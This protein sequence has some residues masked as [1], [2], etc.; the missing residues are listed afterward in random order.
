[1]TIPNHDTYGSRF[2][3]CY[4]F[5]FLSRNKSLMLSFNYEMIIWYILEVIELIQRIEGIS[6]EAD[7][8]GWT[9]LHLVAHY[10][11]IKSTMLLLEY[12]RDVAYM[13]DKDGR[14]AL[15]IAAH[16]G[17]HMVME[18]I[19]SS[20]P[21]CCELVDKR[22]WNVLHFA[23]DDPILDDFEAYQHIKLIIGAIL[24]NRSL[25]NLLNQKDTDG[26][27]P[28]HYLLR[29]SSCWLDTNDHWHTIGKD[30][31]FFDPRVDKMAFNNEN[32][33]AWEIA[34][35]V[36]D[37]SIQKSLD[38]FKEVSFTPYGRVPEVDEKIRE[39]LKKEKK[40]NRKKATEEEEKRNEE[41]KEN[42][43]K[44]IEEEEKR[45]EEEKKRKEEEERKEEEKR[46]E[47]E[48]KRKE[49]EERKKEEQ[50]RMEKEVDRK[51]A[52]SHLVVAALITTV[53]FATSITMPGGFVGGGEK[54]LPAGSAILRTS[55]AFKAFIIT[56]VLAMV[57][58]SSAVFIHLF[59][60][61][62]PDKF[63]SDA[64]DFLHTLAFTF[65]LLAMIPMVLAF[66]TGTYAVLAHSL[67]VA[68]PACIIGLSFFPIFIFIFRRI[69]IEVMK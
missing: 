1:M 44:A 56:D 4:D 21:D 68:I 59:L 7:Q 52:E 22:G 15:H 49:E 60:P 64:H 13:K 50:E 62:M 51:A 57:L 8:K 39:N 69:W 24:E 45:N 12:D 61:I 33:H 66:I 27:T 41:K 18:K 14:T 16:R 34:L 38:I 48:K 28:L 31:L 65:L 47:E 2:Y 46:N 36:T 26:N 20:C 5:F 40:E 30:N 11:K 63:L 42:M 37:V 43:K 29:R 17:H 55:A 9:P 10:N 54:S 53:T 19:I 25:G 58:S 32:L 6:K 35:T 23:A 67:D 3:S